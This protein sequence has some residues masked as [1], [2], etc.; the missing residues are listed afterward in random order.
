MDEKLKHINFE[1]RDLFSIDLVEAYWPHGWDELVLDT[2]KALRDYSYAN[3]IQVDIMQ[4]KEKFGGLRIYT[5]S[6]ENKEVNRIIEKAEHDS[7][8]TCQRCGAN[9][10]SVGPRAF[11]GDSRVIGTLCKACVE[12]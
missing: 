5:N 1:Y 2:F 8:G 6:Y 4:I 10:D 7:F 9:D 3:D 12:R 11:P